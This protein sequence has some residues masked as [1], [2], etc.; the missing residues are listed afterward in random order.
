[1]F[2][3]IF[4]GINHASLITEKY[5]IKTNNTF[6][7]PLVGSSAFMSLA[8]RYPLKSTSTFQKESTCSM[9]NEPQVCIVEEPVE[10]GNR[11][12]KILDQSIC[13]MNSKTMD[14]IENYEEREGVDSNVSC[15]TNGSVIC[16][17]DESNSNMLESESAQR[18]GSEHSPV[19]SGTISGMTEEGQES[20]CHVSVRKELN[21][22]FPSQLSGATFQT[23]G[24][25]SIDQN[26]EKI[27]SFSD[28]N[29]E[30]EDLPSTAQF[31]IYHSGT[32]FRE[33]LEMASS[34]MLHEVNSQRDKSTENFRDACDQ[35]IDLNH[36]N[37]VG[38]LEKSDV[39]LTR[40]TFETPI[41]K[42]YA[43][44][45]TPNSGVLEVNCYDPLKIEVPSSDSSKN[46]GEN[47]KRHSF[48]TD[49]NSKAAF[50][51]SHGMISQLHS[52]Q[53]I[54]HEQ[55]NVFIISGQTQDPMQK[56]RDQ[57]FG[58]HKNEKKKKNSKKNSKKE[59][60][61]KKAAPKKAAPKKAAPKKAAPKKAAPKKAAPKKLKSEKEENNFD[62]DSL[63]I[64]AQA[65]AGKR[66]KT[67][68]TMDSAD[69]DAVRRA[70]LSEIS[71]IIRERGMNNLLADR[72]KVESKIVKCI[73]QHLSERE[74]LKNRLCQMNYYAGFP[75]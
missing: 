22:V 60:A 61:P 15:R 21:N 43:L 27:G 51:N 40:D 49:S 9:V 59:P 2:Q 52:L 57:K 41:T 13:E 62:W 68:N 58:D 33:L 74:K 71:K 67:E 32:S 30:I 14:I 66:E 54:N 69:W 23:S 50:V 37:Q 5:T 3:T 65:R 35:S 19:E 46:K 20:L 26:T 17:A 70:D 29:S 34:T 55:H 31:N 25:F 73:C 64:Q 36:D 48:R 6:I 47:D 18:R 7:F 56:A 44:E 39:T 11:D 28:S 53:E 63:R 4:P 24:D 12:R 16:V 10:N 45:A 8:A 72:I 38:N 42:E 75:Q 1:M